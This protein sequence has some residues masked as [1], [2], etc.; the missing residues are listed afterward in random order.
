MPARLGWK[1]ALLCVA[2]VL[3]VA[4]AS[5]PQRAR[6]DELRLDTE[7]AGR[8]RHAAALGKAAVAPAAAQ[9]LASQLAGLVPVLLRPAQER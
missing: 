6:H 2:S 7:T 3:L 8:L 9:V 5:S 4:C 1:P